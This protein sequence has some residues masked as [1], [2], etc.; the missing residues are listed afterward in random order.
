MLYPS[1][2]DGLI[3]LYFPHFYSNNLQITGF[4]VDIDNRVMVAK[5][6]HIGY[7]FHRTLSIL[8]QIIFIFLIP[9]LYLLLHYL[10]TNREEKKRRITHVDSS[11]LSVSSSATITP[12]LLQ[13]RL[14][15]LPP[16]KRI[17]ITVIYN[18]I[19][20]RNPANTLT[21]I[22]PTTVY[23]HYAANWIDAGTQPR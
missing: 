16:N 15:K 20:S 19:L 21:L 3:I 4:S 14:A 18:T 10:S 7:D 1:L 9:Y 22:L 13:I 17:R 12:S 11:L 6:E 23:P 5:V 8:F 2:L